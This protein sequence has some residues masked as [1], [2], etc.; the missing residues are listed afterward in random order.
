MSIF[1]NSLRR[2]YKYIVNIIPF[3][4]PWAALLGYGI[5]TLDLISL[6]I[7]MKASSTFLQS[8]AEVSK[9]LTL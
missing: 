8:L 3:F 2:F 6:V 4:L 9:N 1:T 5:A 7:V